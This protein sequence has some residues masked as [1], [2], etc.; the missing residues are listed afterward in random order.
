[1][2]AAM[3]RSP[4][5]CKAAWA[6]LSWVNTFLQSAPSSIR[7]CTPRSCP[8][9]RRSRLSTS[10]E[11]S[12]GNCMAVVTA[13]TTLSTVARHQGANEHGRD[14][15]RSGTQRACSAGEDGGHERFGCSCHRGLAIGKTGNSRRC[16]RDRASSRRLRS[17]PAASPIP[18]PL[19]AWGTGGGRCSARRRRGRCPSPSRRGRRGSTVRTA[20]VWRRR[21]RHRGSWLRR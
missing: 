9:A 5:R 11:T 18:V 6:A 15:G 19:S 10:S 3:S 7:R 4:V 21:R 13:A 12:S 8:S 14:R 20:I 16:F 2:P 17:R 1:M